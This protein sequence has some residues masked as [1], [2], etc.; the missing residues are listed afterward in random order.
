VQSVKARHNSA[1]TLSFSSSSSSSS[2]ASASSSVAVS[3]VG[4]QI[5]D[6]RTFTPRAHGI[7]PP[8]LSTFVGA[9][10]DPNNEEF[11]SGGE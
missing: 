8:Q 4:T 11:N 3:T 6:A 5:S 1:G 2:S 9:L 10:S 7:L